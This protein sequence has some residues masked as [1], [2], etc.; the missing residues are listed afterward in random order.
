MVRADH[1]K[2]I[3]R[4]DIG[5]RFLGAITIPIARR[6][7]SIT[8]ASH[9]DDRPHGRLVA[10][11]ADD[12][13]FISPG[14]LNRNRLPAHLQ[15]DAIAAPRA[16]AR[17]ECTT[18]LIRGSP[19]DRAAARGNHI[20]H[21]LRGVGLNDKVLAPRR[22]GGQ[23]NI[24]PP[25]DRVGGNGVIIFIE[26]EVPRGERLG[27]IADRA[28]VDRGRRRRGAG[29]EHEA[30]GGHAAV[31]TIRKG[32]REKREPRQNLHGG[33]PGNG[34][35]HAEEAGRGRKGVGEIGLEHGALPGR[36]ALTQAHRKQALAHGHDLFLRPDDRAALLRVIDPEGHLVVGRR[37]GS[38]HRPLRIERLALVVDGVGRTADGLRG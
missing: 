32:R 3:D 7:A 37:G 36:G 26:G 19:R 12:P 2:E 17:G 34:D 24:H 13:P 18:Y 9:R 14:V 20:D 31:G 10:R 8:V 4:E 30:L 1:R 28:G 23:R 29:V 25:R 6:P 16:P 22:D 27:R 38:E 33:L 15:L 11:I 35:G 5:A 21:V